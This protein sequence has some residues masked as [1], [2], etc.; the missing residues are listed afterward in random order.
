MHKGPTIR[1]LNKDAFDV[2][3]VDEAA[4]AFTD[5][6]FIVEHVGLPRFEDF[7]YIA[8]QEPNVYAGLAVLS[9]LIHKRPHFFGEV[10]GEVLFWL[11]PDSKSVG[12]SPERGVQ[13][14]YLPGVARSAE[15]E[16]QSI[17]SVSYQIESSVS[18]AIGQ[19]SVVSKEA[20]RAI[21]LFNFSTFAV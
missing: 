17:A 1:P 3:D 21:D 8:A 15:R 14:F 4:T 6:N 12:R 16:S 5:L 20:S 9:A 18:V 10:L 7:C 11:G 2:A 19:L 13:F